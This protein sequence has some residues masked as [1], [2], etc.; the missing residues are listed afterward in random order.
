MSTALS[1]VWLVIHLLPSN[2]KTTA[3]GLPG[4]INTYA[5]ALQNPVRLA[6][7]FGL[8]AEICHR[9]IQGY[10]IP[11]RHCFVRFNQDNNDTPSFTPQGVGPAAAPDGAACVSRG[12]V[13]L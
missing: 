6:D 5:Y 10:I 9:L 4:G 8:D 3:S 11:G 1:A 2:E 13:L 12:Q 7:P